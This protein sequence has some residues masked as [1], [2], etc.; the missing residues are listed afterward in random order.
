MADWG[1]A[2]SFVIANEG[3]RVS[4]H[5]ADRGGTSKYGISARSHPGLDIEN[6]TLEQAQGIYE[7]EYWVP[8]RAG[9][10]VATRIS[11][12]YFDA[13]VNVG[14]RRAGTVLQEV[15]NFFTPG[16]CVV[17]GSVGS[18]TLTAIQ[19][20]TDKRGLDTLTFILAYGARLWETYRSLVATDPKQAA[21]GRGWT[22]RCFRIP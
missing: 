1:R 8:S 6:L 13:Y 12:K 15:L 4:R 7:R 18:K 16:A 14:A 10:I 9:E 22:A 2:F 20:F 21:F 17:D 11:T 3:T 5:P 19:E